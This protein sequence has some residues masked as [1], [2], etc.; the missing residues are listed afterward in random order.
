LDADARAFAA[1]SPV[2]G[3]LTQWCSAW[4]WKR[5]GSGTLLI[6]RACS[7]TLLLHAPNANAAQRDA[8]FRWCDSAYWLPGADSV[9]GETYDAGAVAVCAK[10][11]VWTLRPPTEP[12]PR[13]IFG[14]STAAV[15]ARQDAFVGERMLPAEGALRRS[16]LAFAP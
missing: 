16:T 9:W 2:Q 8:V 11:L 3:Y 12:F 14:Q 5:D 10:A 15:A 4:A 1:A 7:L 13:G 6:T